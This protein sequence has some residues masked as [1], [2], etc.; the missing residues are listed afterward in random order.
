MFAV[1]KYLNLHFKKSN[2]YESYMRI[3][4]GDL[5]INAELLNVLQCCVVLCYICRM[6]ICELVSYHKVC[7][8][9]LHTAVASV[10]ST[11]NLLLHLWQA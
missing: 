10:S 3:D 2:T 5:G 4:I 9:N 8:E 1:W 11:P 6:I 7:L